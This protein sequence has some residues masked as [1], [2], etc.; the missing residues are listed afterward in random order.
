[1]VE[2][3]DEELTVRTEDGR[4]MTFKV[5]DDTRVT[6]PGARAR[7]AEERDAIEDL[8]TGDRVMVQYR[9]GETPTEH[10]A[11]SVQIRGE[12]PG[13]AAQTQQQQTER[14]A[15]QERQPQ[16]RQQEERQQQQFQEDDGDEFEEE[17]LPATSGNLPLVALMGLLAMLGAMGAA[18]WGYSHG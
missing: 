13:A 1:V 7:D 18:R 10:V 5:D 9:T 6:D 2:A 4:T 16:E 15:Q 14:F 11:V 17:E 8:N 3:S 12:D